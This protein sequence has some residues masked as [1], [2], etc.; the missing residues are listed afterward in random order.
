MS[1]SESKFDTPGRE[2]ARLVFYPKGS[3]RDIFLCI[4][5]IGLGALLIWIFLDIGRLRP[6]RGAYSISSDRCSEV[7]LSLLA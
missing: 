4:A 7:Y 3:R 1:M 6:W 5:G 2:E